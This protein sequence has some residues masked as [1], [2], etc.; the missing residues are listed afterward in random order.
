MTSIRPVIQ[1]PTRNRRSHCNWNPEVSAADFA[2]FLQHVS[3]HQPKVNVSSKNYK[4]QWY[5]TSSACD[6]TATPCSYLLFSKNH[7]HTH[8]HTHTPRTDVR[9]RR[10]AACSSSSS[11]RQVVDAQR[12]LLL[13]SDQMMCS[14]FLTS[15]EE[16]NVCNELNQNESLKITQQNMNVEE[17]MTFLR[18]VMTKEWWEITGYVSLPTWNELT[19]II[20]LQYKR[21]SISTHSLM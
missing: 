6:Q 15:F 13:L 5:Q 12:Q 8:T 14:Y 19:L 21:N 2:D 18:F 16:W 3:I 17:K 11:N 7:C 20:I 10:A 1:K 9:S 4:L